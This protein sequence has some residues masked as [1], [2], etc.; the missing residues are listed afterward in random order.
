MVVQMAAHAGQVVQQR[1]AV[2]LQVRARA[3]AAGHQDLRGLKGAGAQQHLA[4]HLQTVAAAVAHVLDAA[5]AAAIEHDAGDLGA[6]DHLQVG[7]AQ[8]R[9]QIGLGGAA[10]FTVAVRGLVP[11]HAVLRGAVEVGIQRQAGLHTGLD[12]ALGQRVGAAQVLHAQRAVGA[13]QV[14]TAAQVALGLAEPGQHVVER[15]AGVAG[16][17]PV[18]VV[19]PLATDVDHGVDRARPA[20]H[21]AARLVAA[22]AVQAG[23]R[24]GLEAPVDALGL[25]HQRQTGRAV[26][27]H[28]AVDTAGLQQG[29]AH[30]RIFTESR[31]QHAAGRAAA[32][33]HIVVHAWVSWMSWPAPAAPANPS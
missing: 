19:L 33:H 13:V 31:C 21:L 25:G 23:L 29:H 6:S 26:D 2:L 32:D 12:E 17:G 27:Q 24:H 8:R 10:S 1:D 11:A 4:A 16:S 28:A 22:A 18:V 15:P 5:G 14:V 7:P 20:Q 30:L 3:D 9:R